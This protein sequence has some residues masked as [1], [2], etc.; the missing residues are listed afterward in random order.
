MATQSSNGFPTELNWAETDLTVKSITTQTVSSGEQVITDEYING[1]IEEA[2]SDRFG[3]ISLEAIPIFTE[4]INV[5]LTQVPRTPPAGGSTITAV[6]TSK[7]Q[8]AKTYNLETIRGGNYPTASFN[9][10]YDRFEIFDDF[11]VAT[12][13]NPVVEIDS[14]GNFTMTVSSITAT[15]NSAVYVVFFDKLNRYLASSL[16]AIV[17]N[18]IS[19]SYPSSYTIN[20]LTGAVTENT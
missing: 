13:D 11:S 14:S 4:D 1:L 15:D 5:E 2:I 10:I 7:V 8:L 6:F 19:Y 16:G 17:N 9:S 18:T 20:H 12:W 3:L